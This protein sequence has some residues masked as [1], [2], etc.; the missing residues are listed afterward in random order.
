MHLLPI[1]ILPNLLCCRPA[2]IT[3]CP[4]QST[5][6]GPHCKLG[7]FTIQQHQKHSSVLICYLFIFNI[8]VQDSSHHTVP[9]RCTATTITPPSWMATM[10][11]PTTH[12]LCMFHHHFTHLT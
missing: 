8:P 4:G 12:R 9:S 3:F 1:L 11:R 7:W 2:Q 6:H 5:M 10:H